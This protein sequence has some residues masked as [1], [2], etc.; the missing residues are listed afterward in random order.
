MARCC[1]EEV[2]HYCVAEYA[3]PEPGSSSILKGAESNRERKRVPLNIQVLI[4]LHANFGSSLRPNDQPPPL[5]DASRCHFPHSAPYLAIK[6]SD[7]RA[8]SNHS[9]SETSST[10]TANQSSSHETHPIA[11]EPRAGS[12]SNSFT[13]GSDLGIEMDFFAAISDLDSWS[14]SLISDPDIFQPDLENPKPGYDLTTEPVNI[15]NSTG[16][17]GSTGGLDVHV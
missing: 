10:T 12:S 11:T 9:S 17:T 16:S 3:D 4:D 5:S 7:L 2:I 13:N 15:S 1:I 8:S 14:S 6:A